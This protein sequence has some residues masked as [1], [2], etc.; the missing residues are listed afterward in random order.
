MKSLDKI[1]GYSAMVGAA[2]TIVYLLTTEYRASVIWS[3]LTSW[4]VAIII[5]R[6]GSGRLKEVSALHIVT[7]FYSFI[8]G[9]T[10]C[11]LLFP[12]TIPLAR[13][14]KKDKESKRTPTQVRVLCELEKCNL[15][16]ET[17]LRSVA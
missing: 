3:I 9:L 16:R 1:V 14:Y 2:S 13:K 5:T 15:H 7:V 17:R 11:L 6:Y 12:I 4:L 8:F 10:V